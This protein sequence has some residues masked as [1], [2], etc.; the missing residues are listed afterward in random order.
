MKKKIAILGSSGL[1][2]RELNKFFIKKEYPVLSGT[3]K[4]VDVTNF[5]SLVKFLKAEKPD[6]IINAAVMVSVEECEKNPGAAFL[7]NSVGPQN[8]IKAIAELKIPKAIVIQISTSDIFGNNKKLFREDDSPYPTNI[9][10]LSK[11]A[12]EKIFESAARVNNL[13]Y[14]IVRTSWLYGEGRENF[15]DLIAKSLIAKKSF[16]VIGDQYNICTWTH[17]LAL[18]IGELVDRASNHDS[19]I[20]HI[21]NGYTE[22]VSKY[23]IGLE[24]AKILNLDAKLLKKVSKDEIFK[25]ERPNSAILINS[26]SQ[27]LRDWRVA[28]KEYLLSRYGN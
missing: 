14:F 6:V 20:Y 15:V 4:D 18:A 13:K 21:L 3:S 25:T 24:I 12:G 27:T 9:Y 5:S 19:G 16:P 28:L 1:L 17:D 26:R 22:E 23:D 2:G 7:V 11:F 8:V 10:G